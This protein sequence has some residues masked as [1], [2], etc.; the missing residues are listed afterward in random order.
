MFSPAGKAPS[1]HRP[2]I[3]VVDDEPML[4]ELACIILEPV[5]YEVQTFR[6]P[7][8]ALKTFKAAQPRP[9]LVIT[10]FAMHSLTGTELLEACRRLEPAQKVL[11][12]SGTIG[13]EVFSNAPCK[14]DSF[15]PK[16]Y[17][18]RQLLE[19]VKSLL[20]G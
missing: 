20:T 10:D 19:A 7:E 5:G 4:L 18:A 8:S 2:V 13:P 15:L 3:Y 1:A 6:D 9:A 16:P 11:L 17:H 12:I 14:P